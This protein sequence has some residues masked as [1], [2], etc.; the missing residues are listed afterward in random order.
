MN[1]TTADEKKKKPTGTLLWLVIAVY[2]FLLPNARLAYDAIVNVYGQNAAGRV[3]IITVCILG[4]IYALAVYRVHKSLR[5]LIF[6]IP[7][8]V[9]AY[10]I[11]HLE[12]NPN[13][14]IHIP[15]Y[16]LMAWLLFAALSK[17]YASRDL[18]L[19]IFLCT[20]A[21]GVVDELEQG[22][23]PAR[24]YGWSDMIVN[25]ASG[26]IGIFTL[27]GIKQTQKADWQWAKMLKKSIAPTGLV[28]AGLAGAVIMCVSLFRVQAQG[29]FWGVYPQWLFYWNM[30][31]L[32][33]A[34]MLIISGRYEI[35]VHNRQQVL[36]NES[37]FSYEANIIRL[38]ILPLSVIMA[39]MY[40]LVIYTAVSGV[41][42]R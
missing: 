32:L 39:Y 15:E 29:V 17:G 2:T 4:L 3:P 27:M 40:V 21:L 22:I 34:A 24:F 41:P 25:S 13:K 28:V 37:A 35:Q 19:L 38:W 5:N 18:Y 30:L 33:L 14:H 12:K 10:L 11:M 20:A 26:L 23:H 8:G 31:Y 16:V 7:C 1:R 36:Q 42:F 9:I 6:L